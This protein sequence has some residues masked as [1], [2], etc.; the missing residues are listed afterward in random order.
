L[1]ASKAANPA[2]QSQLQQTLL[3]LAGLVVQEGMQRSGTMGW[4]M[5]M[6]PA[7]LEIPRVMLGTG[8]M[9]RALP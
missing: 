9:P 8:R 7:A 4:Q 5:M 2:W 1:A 6:V 3:L